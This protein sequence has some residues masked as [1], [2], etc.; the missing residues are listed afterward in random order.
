MPSPLLPVFLLLFL[1]E[2]GLVG[3][4]QLWMHLASL[5]RRCHPPAMTLRPPWVL[6]CGES[7]QGVQQQPATANTTRARSHPRPYPNLAEAGQSQNKAGQSH[8]DHKLRFPAESQASSTVYL[9]PARGSRAGK[10]RMGM[11][12]QGKQLSCSSIP[13]YCSCI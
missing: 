5:N 7:R 2:M 9:L 13:G 6:Q 12:G 1:L 8:P 4:H 11:D 10:V 3:S